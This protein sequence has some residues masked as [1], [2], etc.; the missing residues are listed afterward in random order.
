MTYCHDIMLY[1]YVTN[2][3]LDIL[4]IYLLLENY[5]VYYVL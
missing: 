2:I 1:R 3:T 5:I 4:G